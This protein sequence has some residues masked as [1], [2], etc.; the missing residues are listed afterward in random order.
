[1]SIIRRN[2]L[3]IVADILAALQS[4]ELR[5]THLLYK[6]NLSHA[7]L[8]EYLKELIAKGFVEEFETDKGKRFRITETGIR[9]YYEC[10]RINEFV[11]TPGA[12][13]GRAAG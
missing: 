13:F 1:M 5:F 2:R 10:Q 12:Q 11:N 6:S 3:T 8:N 7:K 4:K 9:F